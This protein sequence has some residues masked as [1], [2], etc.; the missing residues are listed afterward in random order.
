MSLQGA[1]YWPWMQKGYDRYGKTMQGDRAEI[2]KMVLRKQNGEQKWLVYRKNL[3]F[4]VFHD[5]RSFIIQYKIYNQSIYNKDILTTWG[6][7]Q[8]QPLTRYE[9]FA[10]CFFHSVCTQSLSPKTVYNFFCSQI[11]D[12]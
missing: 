9:S 2:D 12:H 1:L 3:L 6:H 11:Q 8:I 7:D 5:I 4:G 10:T